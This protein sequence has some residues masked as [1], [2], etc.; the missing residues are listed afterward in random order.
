MSQH[1]L[2]PTTFNVSSNAL[3]PTESYTV[4]QELWDRVQ[5]FRNQGKYRTALEEVLNVL[6]Q[7]PD[8]EGTLRLAA[9]T[10]GGSRSE[11]LQAKEP[12]PSGMLGDTRLDPIFTQ[13]SRCKNT[14]WI[15]LNWMFDSGGHISVMSPVGLQCQECGYVMCRECLKTIQNKFGLGYSTYSKICPNCGQSALGAPVF[16]TGRTSTQMKH[17]KGILS[18]VLIFREGPLVPDAEYI[19]EIL[20]NV[21][22]EALTSSVIYSAFPVSFWPEDISIYGI[23]IALTQGIPLDEYDQA[24]GQDMDGNRLYFMRIYQ[25]RD[26][27]KPG[28]VP[29]SKAT[30]KRPLPVSSRKP[31]GWKE[32]SKRLFAP[33][34]RRSSIEKKEPPGRDAARPGDIT[35]LVDE[36]IRKHVTRMLEMIQESGA[37]EPAVRKLKLFQSPLMTAKI[38][39]SALE[40][41]R[42]AFLDNTHH[43]QNSTSDEFSLIVS[44]VPSV[45]LEQIRSK[46]FP[47]GYVSFLDDQARQTN[48][49]LGEKDLV[50]WVLCSDRHHF[51]VHLTCLSTGFALWGQDLLTSEEKKRYMN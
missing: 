19:K 43:W 51:M 32:F 9:A 16:P 36:M 47:R 49:S 3:R 26:E 41:L 6:A 37:P 23:T 39:Q 18:R 24:N 48:H 20:E 50:H 40:E 11:Q 21:Y 1:K 22:P 33:L 46:Y 35:M 13:C 25:S 17:I 8:D 7:K 27:A 4:D 31:S 30:S 28:Q 34:S 15:S 2:P 38:R 12:I 5:K 42:K 44:A 45:D 14:Q 10:I 29:A